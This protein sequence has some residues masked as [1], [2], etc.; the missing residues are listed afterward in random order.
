[1]CQY[2]SQMGTHTEGAS[3]PEM[4][5]DMT[6]GTRIIDMAQEGGKCES[7]ISSWAPMIQR[8]SEARGEEWHRKEVGSKACWDMPVIP[9]LGKWW[10]ED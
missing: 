9:V 8:Q 6:L 10:W 4:C 1:M 7:Y 3:L 2:L 5:T